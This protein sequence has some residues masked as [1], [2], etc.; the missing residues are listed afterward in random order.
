[1]RGKRYILYP[2][3]SAAQ[4][5]FKVFSIFIPLPTA[6][7][8]PE[9]S[10]T[11]HQLCHSSVHTTVLLTLSSSISSYLFLERTLPDICNVSSCK[12]VWAP[13]METLLWYT[14]IFLDLSGILGHWWKE[15]GK[16]NMMKPPPSYTFHFSF[17]RTEVRNYK[18]ITQ[19]P[20]YFSLNKFTWQP[21]CIWSP[22]FYRSSW[23]LK[24]H[25]NFQLDFLHE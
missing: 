8:G 24:L 17:R 3:S 21:D 19:I 11:S 4:G 2:G 7:I 20:L 14:F 16:Y 5:V 13:C 15:S 9:K 22:A 12:A 6:L 1:M 18:D 23:A 25:C 10:R